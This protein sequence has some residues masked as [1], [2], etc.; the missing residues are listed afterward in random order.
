M[1]ICNRFHARQANSGDNFLEGIP[2]FNTCTYKP[3]WTKGD[4]W[5]L[6]CKNPSLMLKISYAGSLGQPFHCNSLL[7][8]ATQPK[9]AKTITK[10]PY[11]G[12]LSLHP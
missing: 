1:S 11:L 5:D 3:P 7:N 4:G 6:D 2:L 9:V 10:T 8:Y 12:G